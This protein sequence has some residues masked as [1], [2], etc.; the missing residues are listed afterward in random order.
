MDGID[1]TISE[2][3]A[4]SSHVEGYVLYDPETE[5]FLGTK[6]D[7]TFE[8]AWVCYWSDMPAG[9]RRFDIIADNAR[10]KELWTFLGGSKEY[11]M[12]RYIA[13]PFM[14]WPQKDMIRVSHIHSVLLKNINEENFWIDT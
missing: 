3:W 8:Q 7:V 10:T 9:G 4:T 13:V 12:D 1:E 2:I 14:Y 11:I 6:T 5:L